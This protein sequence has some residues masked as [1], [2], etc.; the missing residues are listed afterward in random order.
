MHDPMKLIQSIPQKESRGKLFTDNSLSQDSDNWKSEQAFQIF[1][2][3]A[4][5]NR[6]IT[7]KASRVTESGISE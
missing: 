3:P 2:W 6:K 7:E 4:L 5:H 1:K